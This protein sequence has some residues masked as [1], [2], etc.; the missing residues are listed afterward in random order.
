[1]QKARQ[2]FY[3]F[4]AAGVINVGSQ[5]FAI[6]VLI[7]LSKSLIIPLLAAHV[8]YKYK[9]SKH[10]L[11]ALFFSWLGDLFLI[12][13]G[14]YSFI[15]G[16]ASFWVTQILYCKL[17]LVSLKGS[18]GQQFVKQSGRIPLLLLGSFLAGML[19]LMFPSLGVLKLPVSL[20]AITLS[21]T[22]FLGLVIALEERNRLSLLLAVGCLLF[23]V[24]DSMIAF[25]A[26]Y[27]KTKVFSYWVMATYIPAQFLISK[28]LATVVVK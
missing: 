28:H 12:P 24:S 10:Y 21:T 13:T 2:F 6:E 14:Q 8:F 17:M 15:L 23:V 4:I 25:D 18:L 26:F 1:M 19:Y 16:I 3:A 9:P 27:F 5:I 22:G 20:Y 7:P 11:L